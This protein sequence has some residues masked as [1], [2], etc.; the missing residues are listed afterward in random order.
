MTLAPTRYG[1][2]TDTF[3]LVVGALSE[4]RGRPV[5]DATAD[6]SLFH[7]IG[8]DSTGVLDLLLH[9][10][11]AFGVEFDV[12]EL[13]MRDFATVGTL[14]AFVQRETGR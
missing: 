10:S 4:V 6:T 13:R 7:E 12:E 11:D 14:T 9:L 5:L 8:L 3:G 2:E 1:T